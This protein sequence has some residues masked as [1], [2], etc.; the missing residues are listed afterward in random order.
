MPAV[1]VR[2]EGLSADDVVEVL[3]RGLGPGYEVRADGG[4]EV[5]VR[6]G[7]LSGRRSL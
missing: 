7:T 4:T 6:R 2:R 5:L 3:R 1:E